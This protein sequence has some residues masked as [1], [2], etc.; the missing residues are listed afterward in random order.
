MPIEVENAN[1][2]F[3]SN[4]HLAKN[5]IHRMFRQPYN[6]AKSKSIEY[7]DLIQYA[8]EG[9]WKACL[10]YS[11]KH[12]KFETY[13]INNI[14][15]AVQNGLNRETNLIKYNPN[16]MPKEEDRYILT[17]YNSPIN[18]REDG[19][20]MEL[21]EAIPCENKRPHDLILEK[22]EV[23]QLTKNLNER[24]KRIVELKTEVLTDKQIAKKFGVTFQ[25][26]NRSIHNIRR[27]ILATKQEVTK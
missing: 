12:S 26:I 24:E 10:T 9:L 19:E 8:Y 18:S 4:K 3:E 15:W 17:S 27:K 5:T 2:L 7:E 13:A 22:D 16:N 14:R 21:S 1:F 20:S 25:A 11:N 6:L 23:C